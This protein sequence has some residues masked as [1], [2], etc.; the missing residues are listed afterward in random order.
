MNIF[1]SFQIISSR[2]IDTVSNMS[3]FLNTI[4]LPI[5]GDTSDPEVIDVINNFSPRT[6]LFEGSES[7]RINSLSN[8]RMTLVHQYLDGQNLDVSETIEINLNS[9]DDTLDTVLKSEVFHGSPNGITSMSD[10]LNTV[11]ASIATNSVVN[12]I[13]NLYNRASDEDDSI[14]ASDVV[15][16]IDTK[17]SE[18]GS[19]KG[20]STLK[21]YFVSAGGKVSN[22]EWANC[23]TSLY[24]RASNALGN[25]D[26]SGFNDV[27]PK[28]DEFNWAVIPQIASTLLQAVSFALLGVGKVIGVIVQLIGSVINFAATAV[29]GN[30]KYSKS[31]AINC[32]LNVPIVARKTNSAG[33]DYIRKYSSPFCDYYIWRYDNVL[34]ENAF[35]KPCLHS[36]GDI[37]FRVHH[38]DDP[39]RLQDSGVDIFGE[40]TVGGQA[41]FAVYNGLS[42][43]KNK[44]YHASFREIVND[45]DGS[46]TGRLHLG[47]A[48]SLFMICCSALAGREYWFDYWPTTSWGQRVP[49]FSVNLTVT[50]NLLLK[51]NANLYEIM[52][53][54][55]SLFISGTLPGSSVDASIFTKSL[56]NCIKSFRNLTGT[57]T[58]INEFFPLVVISEIQDEANITS[59]VGWN[60]NNDVCPSSV[61]SPY[62]S[63]TL[64]LENAGTTWGFDQALTYH[65]AVNFSPV[66]SPEWANCLVVKYAVKY[67]S[68]TITDYTN[69]TLNELR[70]L[71]SIENV[72][73]PTKYTYTYPTASFIGKW[74]TFTAVAATVAV[75]VFGVMAG[76]RAIKNKYQRYQ[77]KKAKQLQRMYNNLD[78][79]DPASVASY[80]KAVR[81][82]NL[83]NRFLPGNY[84]FNATGGRADYIASA[85]SDLQM[86]VVDTVGSIS[87]YSSSSGISI[88]SVYRVI[89]D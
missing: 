79:A 38:A 9:D 66:K 89:S 57:Y 62:S 17:I 23:L 25:N 34:Y 46:S 10:L 5:V 41:L 26:I 43:A 15:S 56:A 77:V 70:D 52:C 59:A 27:M 4:S 71:I 1:D 45:I 44:S 65:Q 40:F 61:V 88:D 29:G 3:D 13:T 85:S 87:G 64:S 22:L 16:L 7:F 51:E 76:I 55:V 30:D 14:L 50:D 37:P 35:L 68:D 54:L 36:D 31:R 42:I 47:F 6:I 60:V 72:Y 69:M 81:R 8:S 12:Q 18:Y 78:P 21:N 33:S 63:P 11:K 73:L 83:L 28:V 80:H 32:Y 20:L 74:L 82:Y 75:S 49:I 39:H 48:T 86:G 58:R 53:A 67:C 24:Q 84:S 2:L 19:T